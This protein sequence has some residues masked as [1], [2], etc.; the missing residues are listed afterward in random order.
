MNRSGWIVGLMFA[1]RMA[2]A[3]CIGTAACSGN[4]DVDVDGEVNVDS[5]PPA[6]VT[7]ETLVTSGGDARM[8]CEGEADPFF[9]VWEC[10]VDAPQCTACPVW[11]AGDAFEPTPLDQACMECLVFEGCA[12][13][14]DACGV[15]VPL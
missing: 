2:L 5:P 8:L 6:C 9:K 7:C 11:T 10:V 14:L 13:E 12:A 4:V 1:A 3:S 15:S